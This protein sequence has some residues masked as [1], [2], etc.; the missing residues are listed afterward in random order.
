MKCIYNYLILS[1]LLLIA[2]C[3][4]ETVNEDALLAQGLMRYKVNSKIPFTGKSVEK[5][6]SG[7]LSQHTYKNGKRLT[8]TTWAS[9]RQKILEV[10]YDGETRTETR[11]Q[12][13]GLLVAKEVFIEENKLHGT[14]TYWD[15]EGNIMLSQAS[16]DGWLDGATIEWYENGQKK[17]KKTYK[18]SVLEGLAT[19]WHENGQKASECWYKDGTEVAGKSKFWD[20]SGQLKPNPVSE[21]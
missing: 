7:Q 5:S 17:S 3:G 12:D 19:T 16:Q 8:T 13:N 15:A 21:D 4:G 9:N 11:W 6:L 1:Q 18:E 14:S 2:G 20:E 10:E